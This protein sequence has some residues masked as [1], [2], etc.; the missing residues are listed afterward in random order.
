MSG[1]FKKKRSFHSEPQ[2][3]ANVIVAPVPRPLEPPVAFVVPSPVPAPQSPAEPVPAPRAKAWP[4]GAHEFAPG[5]WYV[6]AAGPF[7]KPEE[8]WDL[9]LRV[10][11]SLIHI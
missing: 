7:S 5:A 3:P 6:G 1:L 9:V 8:Y 4:Y 11:L 2:Q 10:Q